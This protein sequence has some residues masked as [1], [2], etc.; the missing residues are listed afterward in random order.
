MSRQVLQSLL[1][2][3]LIKFLLQLVLENI[4]LR[5]LVSVHQLVKQFQFVGGSLKSPH[6]LLLYVLRFIQPWEVVLAL[7][8]VVLRSHRV[9]LLHSL[10]V[11]LSVQLVVHHVLKCWNTDLQQDRSAL[12]YSLSEAAPANLAPRL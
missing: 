2:L 3:R 7:N 9:F 8:R 11:D 5:L 10:L 4:V 1:I 6:V 12:R